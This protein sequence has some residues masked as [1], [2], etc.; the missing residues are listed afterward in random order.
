ME[1][2]NRIA[3]F[4]DSVIDEFLEGAFPLPPPL[5][6]WINAYSG[7]GEGAVD[8]DAFPEP[9]AGPILG[10][11]RAVVLGLNPGTSFPAWQHR[12]GI[13]ANEIR[14]LGGYRH[15]ARTSA[16]SREPWLSDL[17]PVGYYTNRLRLMQR[18]NEDPSLGDEHL[19]TFELYP[20]HSRKVTGAMRPD[21]DIIDSM[22]FKP[23]SET[24]VRHVFA[25]GAEW[26]RVLDGLGLERVVTLGMGGEPYGSRVASRTVSIYR[27]E[28]DF[29][30]VVEKHSGSAGPPSTIETEILREALF[31]RGL[32]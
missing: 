24:G 20:W 31:A 11:A 8:H 15:M 26:F 18:W 16:V 17:G 4:W 1:H 13:L 25:F 27:G 2:R 7:S 12:D 9:Y 3:D 10:D 29:V 23:I 22:I 30:I 14:S 6:R 19:L 32:A 5:D 21:P 28:G